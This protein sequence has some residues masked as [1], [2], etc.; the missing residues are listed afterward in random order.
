VAAFSCRGGSLPGLSSFD[1]LMSWIYLLG[2]LVSLIWNNAA[3]TAFTSGAPVSR[4][5]A[6]RAADR[7]QNHHSAST[8]PVKVYH[9]LGLAT[10]AMAAKQPWTCG[11]GQKVKASASFCGKCGKPWQAAPQPSWDQ[12]QETETYATYAVDAPWQASGWE[13][14]PSPRQRGGAPWRAP[15]PRSRGKGQGAKMGKGGKGKPAPKGKPPEQGQQIPTLQGLPT[16]PVA[17]LPTRTPAPTAPAPSLGAATQGE[18]RKLL[19]ELMAAINTDQLSPDLQR[20]LGAISQGDVHQHGRQMHKLVSEKT[21]LQKEL[22]KLRIDRAVYNAAWETYVVGLLELW[23]KQGET[24]M[25]TMQSYSTAEEELSVKLANA[26]TALATAAAGGSTGDGKGPQLIN[27]DM[28]E[29]EEAELMVDKAIEVEATIRAKNKATHEQ[30]QLQHAKVLGL[31]QQAKEEAAASAADSARQR[32]GSR[33]P[34]RHKGNDAPAFDFKPGGA[35][36][37]DKPATEAGQGPQDGLPPGG[38][39]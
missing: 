14:H 5:E 38:A 30:I 4:L 37:M 27:D 11:C 12:W 28:E 3:A 32:E 18:D 2:L 20:R 6:K 29:D 8:L 26:A 25:Q 39:R 9:I 7:L 33:T 34:R 36:G 17:T 1:I 19:T 15:S 13:R 10:E 16:A 22:D 24:R 21:A 31:L 23:A 35:T